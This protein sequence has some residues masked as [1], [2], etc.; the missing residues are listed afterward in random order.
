MQHFFS[1]FPAFHQY[2]L[3]QKFAT[4]IDENNI[5]PTDV[6]FDSYR[7]F[8][9]DRMCRS[10]VSSLL[11]EVES[12]L[13]FNM[14]NRWFIKDGKVY[15][16]IY[17]RNAYKMWNK[18]IHTRPF[19]LLCR[20]RK[21]ELFFEFGF[22]KENKKGLLI[23]TPPTFFHKI[24]T[25]IEP[26]TRDD[27]LT[28]HIGTPYRPTRYSLNGYI[29]INNIDGAMI[30]LSG[31][32]ACVK[33][34]GLREHDL[35]SS[36]NKLYWHGTGQGERWRLL[37]YCDVV[38]IKND[39]V[40]LKFNTDFFYDRLSIAKMGTPICDGNLN[41]DPYNALSRSTKLAFRCPISKQIIS[42]HPASDWQ[43][44]LIRIPITHRSRQCLLQIQS[45]DQNLYNRLQDWIRRPVVCYW[46]NQNA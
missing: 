36:K 25:T 10:L 29:K 20:K 9:R 42:N 6:L 15:T 1:V 3:S 13:T 4:P 31:N 14:D 19:E 44:V 40:H 35:L 2:A 18:C 5:I 37:G 32:G 34:S 45:H 16:S 8:I 7:H 17:S 12:S 41:Y 33:I 30:D 21:E 24:K 38:S 23:V 46:S 27:F 22:K 39:L 43:S 26:K 28:W 11:A